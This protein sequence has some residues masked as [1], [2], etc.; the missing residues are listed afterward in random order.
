MMNA[1]PTLLIWFP[2]HFKYKV[3]SNLDIWEVLFFCIRERYERQRA[4]VLSASK[5]LSVWRQAALLNF[6]RRLFNV[7]MV[8]GYSPVSNITAWYLQEILNS[9]LA[10]HQLLAFISWNVTDPHIR[11]AQEYEVQQNLLFLFNHH[12]YPHCA[13]VLLNIRYDVP[14]IILIRSVLPFSSIH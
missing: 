11:L 4:S 7:E 14:Q 13:K 8:A 5:I 2:S 10:L 6:K 1:S 9:D 3:M 12:I